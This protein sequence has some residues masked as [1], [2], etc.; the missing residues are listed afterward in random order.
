MSKLQTLKFVIFSRGFV[1]R[2]THLWGLYVVKWAEEITYLIKK[3]KT[4]LFRVPRFVIYLDISPYRYIVLFCFDARAN[5][6]RIFSIALAST[7]EFVNVFFQQIILL[8]T[9]PCTTKQ[10]PG[11]GQTLL[12]L[13]TEKQQTCSFKFRTLTRRRMHAYAHR[14]DEDTNIP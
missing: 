14:Q 13:L 4:R 12:F 3:F 9:S 2:I 5:F 6:S 7:R 1:W 8:D 11:R 10:F